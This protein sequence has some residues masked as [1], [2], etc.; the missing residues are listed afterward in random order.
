[1]TLETLKTNFMD[2]TSDAVS[3]GYLAPG[4]DTVRIEFVN[5]AFTDQF[6]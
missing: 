3:V 6:G 2:L 1:M 4:A 5:K